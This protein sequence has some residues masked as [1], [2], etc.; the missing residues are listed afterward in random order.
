MFDPRLAVVVS[1]CGLDSFFDYMNGDI[2]GWTSDRYMPRLLDYRLAEI[3]F[4]FPEVIGALAPRSCL[5]VAPVGDTNF[6]WR[7]VE[8]IGR[9]AAGVYELHGVPSHLQLEHPA[10]GHRFPPEMRFLAY[11][12][13][14][15]ALLK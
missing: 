15:A 4:D 6:K 13:L 11:E 12:F 7:S 8:M 14:D 2:K 9:A 1:C 3:P 10:C 5:L